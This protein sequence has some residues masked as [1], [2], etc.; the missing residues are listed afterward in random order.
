MT[1]TPPIITLQPGQPGEGMD[2]NVNKP[3]PYPIHVDDKL[4]CTNVPVDGCAFGGTQ[5]DHPR[6][7]GFQKTADPDPVGLVLADD[8]WRSDPDVCVGMFPVFVNRGDMF[9]LTVPIRSVG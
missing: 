5:G 2:Y 4:A 6:L 8:D 7:V 1:E 3:L 9:N